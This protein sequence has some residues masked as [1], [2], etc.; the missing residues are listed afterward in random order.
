MKS[1]I[2]TG[3]DYSVEKTNGDDLGIAI[4]IHHGV[5]F[6]LPFAPYF[7]QQDLGITRHA[8]LQM[9]V[10]LFS[11]AT[12]LTM[13][14]AAPLWGLLADPIWQANHAHP[15]ANFAGCIV[16]SLMGGVHSPVTLIILRLIQGA[17]TGT[18]TAAQAFY[19]EKFRVNIAGWPS[20]A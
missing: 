8:E 2:V 4:F 1:G 20:A 16:M 9:W 10:A 11:A 6:A 5:S 7:L 19:R 15:R 3:Y 18:M 13:G 12:A 17:L 14:I